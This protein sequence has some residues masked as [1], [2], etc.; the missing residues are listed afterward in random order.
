[1]SRGLSTTWTNALDDNQFKLAT[2][3]DIELSSTFRL[4]DYGASLTYNTNTYANS[5]NLIDIAEAKE[6]GALKVNSMAI[7]L[8]GADSSQA[9]IAAFLGGD[10]INKRLLLRR[11]LVNA[12]NVVQ[13]V[14]TYF[15][16]RITGF[17][18]VDSTTET[19]LTVEAAS[20]WVDFDKIRCR[21]TN[22]KSQQSFFPN[23]VGFEYAHNKVKDLRWGRKS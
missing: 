5:Q 20:H 17:D 23:D 19:N 9:Y 10:Y 2:L 14:F 21:R 6:T 15:D 12:S 22:L 3:I 8:T 4:T 13:D 18:I 7:T 16:G 11:A 1:V